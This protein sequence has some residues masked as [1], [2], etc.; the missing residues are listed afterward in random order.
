MNFGSFAV[1]APLGLRRIA[2]CL[3]LLALALCAQMP[4]PDRAFAQTR[5]A[6]AA[7][8]TPKFKAIFE[9][10]NYPDDIT[11]N[12]V[13]FANDRVG[14]ISGKGPGGFIL[15]TADGGA[16]W[17]VQI[18]DPHSNNPELMGLHFLDA[19]HGWAYQSGGQ[20]LRTIDGKTWETV[21]PF[22][23]VPTQFR[24][25]SVRDGYFISGDYA[26]SSLFATHDGGRSWKKMYSCAT[27]LQVNGL[28][29]NTSCYLTDLFFASTKVGYAV[30]GGFD[31]TW[32]AVAKTVDGGTT[33]KVVFASTDVAEATSVFFTDENNG[34]IRLHDR[35]VLIT[36]DGGQTWRG[37]T[38]TAE[39]T[40]K[41]ADPQVGWSCIEQYGP[42]CSITLDGGKSW[43]AHDI[44][45]PEDIQ[46]YSV[47]RRDLVYVVGD[48]GMIYRYRIVPADYTARGI[49]DAPLMT[50]YGGPIVTQLQQMQTQI[51]ALQSQLSA[52]AAASASASG[53]A[54][55]PPGGGFA[56][57]TSAQSSPDAPIA[58]QA[59]PASGGF[60][61]DASAGA[62]GF[63]QS[64]AAPAPT[65]QGAAASGGFS[66]DASAG[67]FTQDPNAAAG[68]FAQDTSSA[69]S[70]QFVQSCCGNQV[71]GLVTSFGS[72]A[73]QVPAFSGQFR[74]LNLLSVGLNMLNDMMS[75]TKQIHDSL[76]ALKKAPDAQ[77]ALAALL[78]LSA[79]LQGAN[80][81]IATQFQNLGAAPATGAPAG[82]IGNQV[83]A[84]PNAPAGGFQQNT[85]SNA[86]PSTPANG[87][88]NGTASNGNQQS[89][90]QNGNQSGSQNG[91]QNSATGNAINKATSALKK[92][93]PF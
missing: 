65:D 41:F 57:N 70:S 7:A 73:T 58:N 27:T 75:R 14:W 51:T 77:T 91:N 2:M 25:V 48:H 40:I 45:L 50:A 5:T 69:P 21:G 87:N 61:Q 23:N 84:D 12:D 81:A 22:G 72:V 63:S 78:T 52:A 46:S 62:Q 36:A 93:L 88:A 74:N 33:W 44:K 85:N 31:G 83:A 54:A 86:A 55:A 20:L 47:P 89:G 60:S 16:N 80:Q 67:G 64:T 66:Q 76:L 68:E 49:V 3:S 82:V 92:K 32:G 8:A 18:G 59:A 1:R 30:G 39:A 15:H 29:R 11:F 17:D 53:S 71:Q 10:M 90:N 43:T 19:T 37:A 4:A 26:G 38:G 28:T 35:R 56:Q 24:F 34:V 9:P 6:Q 79:N 13:F 42:S